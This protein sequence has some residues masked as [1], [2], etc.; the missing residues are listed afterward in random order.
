M[1]KIIFHFKWLKCNKKSRSPPNQNLKFK[2]NLISNTQKVPQHTPFRP[3]N[4]S[5]TSK[6]CILNVPTYYLLN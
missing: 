1:L 2:F 6:Y 3:V 4:I 5:V